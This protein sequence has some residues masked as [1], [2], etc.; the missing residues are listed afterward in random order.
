MN[1]QAHKYYRQLDSLRA[2]AVLMVMFSYFLAG[3]PVRGAITAS[4]CFLC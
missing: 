4:A 1:P 2:V 3:G